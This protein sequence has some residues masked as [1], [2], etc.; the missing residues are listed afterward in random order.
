VVALLLLL[1]SISASAAPAAQEAAEVTAQ[2]IAGVLGRDDLATFTASLDPSA[3]HPRTTTDLRDLIDRFDEIEIDH[4]A[5]SAAQ[6]ENDR[7]TFRLEMQGSA[8]LKARW[9]PVRPLPRH[10]HVEARRVGEEWKILSAKTE[11]SR[12]AATMLAADMQEAE[13]ILAGSLDA[14]RADVIIAYATDAQN[15]E[16]IQHGIALAEKSDD[17]STTIVAM[18]RLVSSVALANPSLGLETARRAEALSCFRGGP[19]DRAG[20]L[21]AM[22][23]AL[24]CAGRIEDSLQSYEEAAGL[25]EH[26]EDPTLPMKALYMYIQSQDTIGNILQAVRAT[27]V[28]ADMAR[29]F[30]WEEGEE[31]QLFSRASLHG[32]LGNRDVARAANHQLM[33]LGQARG[34]RRFH[35]YATFNL[36]HL[37]LE[38]RNF[39]SAAR[40]LRKA[41][42]ILP[43]GGW[44]RSYALC[45]LAAV[46][47][48]LGNLPAAEEALRVAEAE[49][50]TPWTFA[51]IASERSNLHLARGDS[52]E[53][54]KSAQEALRLIAQVQDRPLLDLQ[55]AVLTSLGRALRMAGRN[56][57]AVE[58][59]RHAITATESYREQ[60][61]DDALTRF[62]FFHSYSRAY[63]ELVELLVELRDFAGALRVAEQT[64]ARGLRDVIEHCRI[65]PSASMS[66]A[67]RAR[68]LALDGRVVAINRAL[69]SARQSGQS[70]AS[71]K[72]ELAAARSELDAFRSEVRLAQ[73][74][75]GRRQLYD[76][77]TIALPP[78]STSLAVIEYS[79]T[80]T[81]VIAFIITKS[82]VRAIRIAG[83]R[84]GIERDVH[85]VTRLISSRSPAYGKAARA[86]YDILLAPLERELAGVKTLCVIPDGVLWTVPFH[87]LVT[88]RGRHLIDEYG[89]FYAPSL[90][91]LNKASQS[92]PKTSPRLLALGNPTMAATTRST[93]SSVFRDVT[94]GPLE[95]A[96]TEVLALAKIYPAGS[97]VY[98]RDDAQEKTFKQEAHRF[99]VI[100]I[101]AHAVV[102]DLAPLYSAIVLAANRGDDGLLEAREVVD[103]A[104]N[105]DL[106]VLSACE[107]A[108]G[109][110]GAGEGVVGLS[111]A[112]FAAGCPTTVVS[113][114]NAESAATARLMIGFHRR[115]IAGQTVTQ[116]L[117]GAQI[118]L[119][120]VEDYQHPFYWAPFVA[121]GAAQHSIGSNRP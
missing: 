67:D 36:S 77:E 102:D 63:S 66:P 82:S 52:A 114:W 108:R 17:P 76:G 87:A 84:A 24:K 86:L 85:H 113:Q 96:E 3:P 74:A 111:W 26:C 37:D 16:R 68:S 65:D 6:L 20:A 31:L 15:V 2:L 118:A 97:K 19:D 9:R 57:E 64:K 105:A 44:E 41:F 35:A 70:S 109:R 95:D 79:V 107:T 59:L 45:F 21:L 10:W 61:A 55:V 46:E 60:T 106:A 101:A 22:G 49:G 48:N 4:V 11:A 38:D 100:H 13:R 71:M 5:V 98:S 120:K 99:S 121:V 18:R 28:L 50:I 27:T 54:I 93:A 33:A 103:L 69:L 72:T 23:W 42:G 94:L 90:A 62:A 30:A 88:P 7:L 91:L 116:A 75:V 92:R 56:V 78:G 58:E 32:Q 104:L 112:F 110:V 14:N 83:T 119:R 51:Q 1:S 25:I 73:P 40:L 8:A 43:P 89:I 115:L 117:R 81:Q 39:E 29:A 12:V 80:E 34:N 47:V 53:A